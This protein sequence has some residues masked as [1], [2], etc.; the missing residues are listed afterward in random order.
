[1]KKYRAAIIIIQRYIRGFLAR[2]QYSRLLANKIIKVEPPYL[3]CL[4]TLF[5]RRK[6]RGMSARKGK[7]KKGSKSLIF[8]RIQ[9]SIE[10]ITFR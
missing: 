8:K 5:D 4:L 10:I 2:K 3:R 9:S 1:M 6:K 7:S